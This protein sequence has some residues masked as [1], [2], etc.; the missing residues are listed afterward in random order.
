[1]SE[2]KKTAP[3]Y[4]VTLSVWVPADPNDHEEMVRAAKIV[5]ALKTLKFEDIESLEGAK[6]EIIEA[7][8]RH[9]SKRAV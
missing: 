2:E 1:M 7:K 6:L 5:P 3:G 4:I 9:V 8:S